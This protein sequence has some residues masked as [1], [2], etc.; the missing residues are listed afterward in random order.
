MLES[1]QTGR[2]GKGKGDQWFIEPNH[3]YD[4]TAG[5]IDTAEVLDQEDMAKTVETRGSEILSSRDSF[6]AHS[7]I[8]Y[9]VSTT[10]ARDDFKQSST[11]V[12]CIESCLNKSWTRVQYLSLYRPFLS[13][14]FTKACV[15]FRS[16]R[17]LGILDVFWIS[18]EVYI[19]WF[20]RWKLG[21]ST[22]QSLDVLKKAAQCSRRLI[23][24]CRKEIEN[25]SSIRKRRERKGGEASRSVKH[26]ALSIPLTI[27]YLEMQEKV[28]SRRETRRDEDHGPNIFLFRPSLTQ[29]SVLRWILL[30]RPW[31]GKKGNRILGWAVDQSVTREN[32]ST[33]RDSYII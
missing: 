7:M 14:R 8:R 16:T 24:A 29:S 25:K 11:A 20:S 10:H 31:K 28:V 33:L 5:C 3:R 19:S 4:S 9:I 22:N 27:Q 30:P 21:N 32:S 15:D 23:G 6:V 2:S 17:S 1:G 18:T 26:I 13:S 12:R